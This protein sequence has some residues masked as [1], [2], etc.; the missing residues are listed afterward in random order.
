GSGTSGVNSTFN[1]MSHTCDA[2]ALLAT[3]IAGSIAALK[4]PPM[5]QISLHRFVTIAQ[6]HAIS[7]IHRVSPARHMP[8]AVDVHRCRVVGLLL[9][10][11][12]RFAREDED[13]ACRDEQCCN[14]NE[15]SV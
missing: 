7:R 9:R 3:S 8:G 13:F 10:S 14:E 5:R 12:A 15:P 11:V 2:A 1:R 6:V 4:T